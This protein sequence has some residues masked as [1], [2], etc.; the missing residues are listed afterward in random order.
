MAHVQIHAKSASIIDG[1]YGDDQECTVMV[2]GIDITDSVLADGFAIEWP[3]DMTRQNPIVCLRL[4]ADIL[5]IDMPRA[6]LDAIV[7][8]AGL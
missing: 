8:R 4:S 6:L 1:V 2:D 7:T 5:D 3:E